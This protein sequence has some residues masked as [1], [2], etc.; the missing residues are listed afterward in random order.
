MAWKFCG[1]KKLAQE[2]NRYKKIIKDCVIH[3]SCSY[4]WSTENYNSALTQQ[5]ESLA[6]TV[7]WTISNDSAGNMYSP[8]QLII[9]YTWS[10]T[11]HKFVWCIVSMGLHHTDHIS[12]WHS[13]WLHE[14][15]YTVLNA[16]TEGHRQ[17]TSCHT[18]TCNLKHLSHNMTSHHLHLLSSTLLVVHII[19]HE[20]LKLYW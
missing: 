3:Q 20:I 17:G 6:W 7:H 14:E 15:L 10:Q 8:T 5:I 16:D 4:K 11:F 2:I 9:A 18:S 13:Y 12:S 1:L 19:W